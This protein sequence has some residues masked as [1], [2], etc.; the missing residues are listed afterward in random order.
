MRLDFSGQQSTVNNPATNIQT[1][2]QA[3]IVY[4]EPDYSTMESTAGQDLNPI[5][6]LYLSA[7]K[8]TPE[9]LG[10]IRPQM[11]TMGANA[12]VLEMKDTKGILSWNS[13]VQLATSY[14]TNGTADL[15]ESLAFLKEQGVY[16]V[17]RISVCV[18]EYMALRNTPLALATGEG[19]VYSDDSGIWLD[20]SNSDVQ[21]YTADVARS[22]LRMGF[23]E[24]MLANFEHPILTGETTLAYSQQSSVTL[25]PTIILSGFAM[26]MR[27]A[28]DELGGRL[29]VFC[30]ASAFRSGQTAQT[31]QDP[32]LFGKVFDR[33]YWTTDGNALSSD[34]DLAAQS[35]P[36]SELSTRFVPIIFATG[37]TESWVYPIG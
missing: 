17:A 6:A 16:L 22:L 10:D 29:S 12:L 4:D 13:D 21:S 32:V 5:K 28:V 26:N 2:V 31:G 3:E 19:R 37:S 36:R 34:M 30:N 25:T 27:D 33:L 35:V 1:T 15:S 23:D 14:G 11:E 18:D 8:V 7:S 24:I 9:T 20:F